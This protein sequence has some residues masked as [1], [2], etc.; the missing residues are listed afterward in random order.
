M[1]F[2]G[3]QGG[4]RARCNWR[5]KDVLVSGGGPLRYLINA[6]VLSERVVV[7]AKRDYNGVEEFLGCV[8]VEVRVRVLVHTCVSQSEVVLYACPTNLRRANPFAKFSCFV[9]MACRNIHAPSF[10][11]TSDLILTRSLMTC[12]SSIAR[13]QP[14]MSG[15]AH[16]RRRMSTTR[17]SWRTHDPK[18]DCKKRTIDDVSTR[19]R[20][21]FAQHASDGSVPPSSL[22]CS[23]RLHLWSVL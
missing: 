10:A 22:T 14:I 1:S 9:V 16:Q 19:R 23:C 15:C 21:I 6:A 7:L 13:T 2:L 20:V 18:E 8:V 5:R 3:L 12:A 11:E 17:E 4:H